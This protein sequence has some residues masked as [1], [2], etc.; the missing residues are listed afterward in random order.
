MEITK[1]AEL[2]LSRRYLA[3][4]EEGNPVETVDGLFRRVASAIAEADAHFDSQADTAAVAEE[5]LKAMTR[6]EFL[7]NSPT[8]MNAG[9]PL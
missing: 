3:K 7:P 1:N 8:L 4:D 9:R 6:L 5:F 2:V